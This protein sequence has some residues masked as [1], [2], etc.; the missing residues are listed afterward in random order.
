[1][2]DTVQSIADKYGTTKVRLSFVSFGQTPVVVFDFNT[3]IPDQETLTKELDKVKKETG[4][5]DLVNTVK[6]A[7]E[8]FDT[9]PVR[10]ESKKVLTIVT[11]RKFTNVPISDIRPAV[12]P[13]D[14][15]GIRI[16]TVG[17]GNDPVQEELKNITRTERAVI[18]PKPSDEGMQVADEILKVILNGELSEFLKL[19]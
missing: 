1:M 12:E 13:L 4:N 8:I 10:R 19:S 7:K 9:S 5:P 14:K 6:K 3:T 2:K 16:V 11:H 17:I 18:R 15:D